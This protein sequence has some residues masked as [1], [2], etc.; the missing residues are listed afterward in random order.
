MYLFYLP[1]IH[2]AAGKSLRDRLVRLDY[3]GFVLSA[4]MW[5]T[6][7]MAFISAGI[8]WAWSEGRSI[9]LIVAFAVLLTLYALQQYL[10]IFTTPENRSFPGHLLRSRTQILFY[11]TTTCA[12]TGLFFTTFYIPIYFQFTQNDSSLMAAVR[13]LPYL[14]V[15]ITFN[16]ATGWALPKVKYYMRSQVL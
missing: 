2:P 4:G 13:L 15:T 16:L 12:N 6:F 3:V 9:A 14:L 1:S 10:C 8:I 5:V 7:A 11:I